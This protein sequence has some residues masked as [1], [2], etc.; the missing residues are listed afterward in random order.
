[1]ARWHIVALGSWWVVAVLG[2]WACSEPA[3]FEARET[4]EGDGDAPELV[5]VEGDVPES[6]LDVADLAVDTA[7][8]SVDA[9]E[10]QVDTAEVSVDAADAQDGDLPLVCRDECPG[11]GVRECLTG[12]TYQICARHEDGCFTWSAEQACADAEVC[13]GA[14]QCTPGVAR[15]PIG[16][17][18]ITAGAFLMGSPDDEVGHGD[19]EVQ[20]EVA[21]TRDFCMAATEVTQADFQ[22]LMGYQPAAHGNCGPSC[23]V[24]QVSWHEAAAY[25]N[26]LSV[27]A[28]APLCYQCNG[29]GA[30]VTC[31]ASSGS[32]YDCA[33]FRLPTEAEWEYAARAGSSAALSNGPLLQS[34]CS[35]LDVNL[36]AIGWY[37]GNTQPAGTQPVG[38]KAA[39]AWGLYDMAGNVWEWCHDWH[40]PYASTGGVDPWGPAV[41]GNKVARG[42]S[43][44][45]GASRCRAATRDSAGPNDTNNRRG[46]RPVKR[47]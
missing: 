8:V 39:N 21:L 3:P 35:P 30:D 31:S 44:Y 13:T 25:C 32:P 14:G 43:A 1:M 16:F 41:G 27:E 4:A 12:V 18:I 2:A 38:Q 20:H 7:E 29:G 42:G 6:D 5:E 17:K 40:A 45:D 19:D 28:S 26:A 47:Y 22:R 33:G 23:P 9:A 34:G 11:E 46:F 15:C 10:V 36:D 24:E 37:C